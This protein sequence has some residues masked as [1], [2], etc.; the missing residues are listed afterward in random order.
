MPDWKSFF[1]TALNEINYLLKRKKGYKVT[2]VVIELTSFCN[3][4][5]VMCAK[6]KVVTRQPTHMSFETF[7]NIIDNNK[8][9]SLF[10][11]VGWGETMMNPK[12]FEMLEYLKKNNRRFAITTNGTLLNESNIEKLVRSGISHI[13]ISMDG[14]GEVY[15]SIRGFPYN[16]LE[17]NI[18]FLSKKIKDNNSNIYFEINSITNPEILKQ[19][20]VMLETIGKYVNDIR[21]SSYMDYNNLL[22]TNRTKPC[23]EL[24]RG[25]ITVLNDGSVVPCCMDYNASLVI[26][27]V[28][29]AAYLQEIWNNEK[30]Q[31]I[32]KQHINLKFLNRCA[33]CYETIP[34]DNIEI[35]KKFD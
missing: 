6:N 21:F 27:N 10:I 2:S 26:G 33:T 11:L 12:F 31:K 20:P 35:N 9:I 7:K 24:W 18:I 5:C 14:I 16:K 4:N 29:N 1:Y 13:T 25:M 28:N 15:E 17:K 8:N 22:K 30:A 3:L 32:R 19:I 23:R 34:D